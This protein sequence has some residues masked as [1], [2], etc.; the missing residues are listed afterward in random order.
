MG[1]TTKLVQSILYTEISLLSL[2]LSPAP[3][4]IKKSILNFTTLKIFKPIIHI[5]Y[6]IYAMIFLMFI[7]SVLKL[8]NL[9]SNLPN[10]KSISFN[11][12]EIYHTERN[13]YLSG[14]SLYIA[15]IFKIFGRILINLYKEQDAIHFLKK[16]LNNGQS[17]VSTVI[18]ESGDK[19]NEINDLKQEIKKLNKVV[20][21]YL[22]VIK[23]Y[24]NNKDE[25]LRLL[26][27]YNQLS[28]R[29]RRETKKNK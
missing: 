20:E 19:E 14:F 7:D 18:N 1:I 26:D 15:I 3:K 17:F 6:V 27:K 5:L 23:Q 24:E 4:N 10:F 16:Q 2:L 25:Y 21:G 28:E 9:N 11:H 22:V 12:N 13:F 8:T 29:M